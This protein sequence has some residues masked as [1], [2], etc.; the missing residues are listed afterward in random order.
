MPRAN[1]FHL[2]QAESQVSP[3]AGKLELRESEL[4]E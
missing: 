3:R 2:P 1:D 4:A